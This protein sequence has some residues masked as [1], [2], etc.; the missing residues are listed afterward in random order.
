MSTIENNVINKVEE[1][2][3]KPVVGFE[4]Q[5]EVS[6]TGEVRN[7]ITGYT[8]SQCKDKYG[9]KRVCLSAVY[10]EG[11]RASNYYAVH[12][13]VAKSFIPNPENK[14]CIDHIDGNPSNNYVTNLR[15]VTYK[16]NLN[17]NVT[18]ERMKNILTH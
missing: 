10:R 2:I 11:K 14:P 4:L 12:R 15:W 6:S 18:K 3:W 5:Y 7:K 16:E 17:N 1:V 9:Y 8:I 13:L